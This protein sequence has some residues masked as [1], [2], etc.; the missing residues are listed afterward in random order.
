MFTGFHS[1]DNTAGSRA[2]FIG[3]VFTVLTRNSDDV[4]AGFQFGGV[5]YQSAI[6][7]RSTQVSPLSNIAGGELINQNIV[8][9]GA[10]VDHGMGSGVVAAEIST[11]VIQGQSD[12]IALSGIIVI[13]DNVVENAGGIGVE[14][15]AGEVTQRHDISVTQQDLITGSAPAFGCQGILV[16][17]IVV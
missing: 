9:I 11:C 5:Y 14:A 4:F 6:G 16:I 10:V 12:L 7:F 2:N 15:P 8:N 17:H 13:A 3:V 1:Q